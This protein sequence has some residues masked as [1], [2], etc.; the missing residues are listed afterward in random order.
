MKG[1][2][3]EL[4]AEGNIVEGGILAEGATL[5]PKYL[6]NDDE[7]AKFIGAKKLTSVDF[8]PAGY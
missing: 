3:A 8:N 4:D 2:I 1:D 5:M 6:K 7:K